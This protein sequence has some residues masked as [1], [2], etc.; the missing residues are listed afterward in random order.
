VEA[1]PLLLI[2]GI[3]K[4]KSTVMAIEK[5]QCAVILVISGKGGSAQE[6]LGYWDGDSLGEEG[7]ASPD[8]KSS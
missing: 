6:G 7:A 3:F 8:K 4:K 2:P 5:G 1:S